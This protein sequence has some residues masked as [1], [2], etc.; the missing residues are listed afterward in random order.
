MNQS[1][2]ELR[3]LQ[4]EVPGIRDMRGRIPKQFVE[5]DGLLYHMWTP[6]KKPGEAVEQL[7]LPEQFHQIVCKLAHTIPL[8]GHLGR[9]KTVKRISRRFFWPALFRDVADYC[10]R[11]PECQ[12]TAKGSHRRVPLIPLPIMKEPFERIAL[13]IVGPLPH[14][15]RGNQ[16]ILV[17]CDYATRYPEAMPLRSIDAGTVA[18][19]LIQL[20]ARV[21]IPRE[22]LSDQGTN[23]MSQ[24]LKELYNLLRIHQI[25][26]SPYHPQ[27]DG[28][29]ERFNK[30]LKS[31]LRK[32]VNKE[33]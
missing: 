27:T 8:A 24:L 32:L 23:F 10:R 29:V 2:Q 31:L 9:D 18:E 6:K 28:L 15:R 11:C 33:G 16:Y 4:D 26:T 1:K 20:F 22:I 7:V 19:H 12:R 14:S 5:Q 17:V 21:G 3:K 13:D 25:R 30:T